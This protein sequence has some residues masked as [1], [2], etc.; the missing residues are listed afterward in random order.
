MRNWWRPSPQAAA[1][2]ESS[3]HP[4][5]SEAGGEKTDEIG[6]R[7]K[8]NEQSSGGT[9]KEGREKQMK[10]KRLNMWNSSLRLFL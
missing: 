6:E 3:E 4:E 9:N 10:T 2:G 5:R 8:P 7:G 1:S